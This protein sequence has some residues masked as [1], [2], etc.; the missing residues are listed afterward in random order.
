[1]VKSIWPVVR[2]LGELAYDI[3]REA[4]RPQPIPRGTPLR[5]VDV[6]IQRRASNNAGHETSK[7]RT[8]N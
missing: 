8:W 1:M 3:A 6:E 7:P 5:H 2:F 4:L